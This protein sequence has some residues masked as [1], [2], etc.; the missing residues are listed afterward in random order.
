MAVILLAE[1]SP[2]HT[3]LMRSLLEEAAH[4]VHCVANGKDAMSSI[5]EC[6]PDLVVTDLRMPEMNGLELVQAVAE[7]CPELPTIVVTARGSEALAV[8]ALALGAINFVPKNSLSTLLAHV[9]GRT[10]RM[11]Q[12]DR[13]YEDFSGQLCNPEYSFTLDNQIAGIEPASFY[14]VQSLAAAGRMNPTL[15][16]RVGTAVASALFNAICFGNLELQENEEAVKR[17]LSGDLAGS[18]DVHDRA[19]AEPYCQRKVELKV[20]V[21]QGDTRILV[22]HE[23]PGRLTRMTPAPGTPESFELEQC[24]GL[25][26]M[27]SFMDDV[28]FHSDYS[29]VVMVKSHPED[30]DD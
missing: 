25:M 13:L 19:E 27:T 18:Q 15:R 17:L 2:T 24:R 26:L 8:D 9:V 28:L 7:N 10:V 11:S 20:S 3:A 6:C 21:G 12:T 14:V 1:D 29:E 4:K 22:S 16:M 30:C 5:E 23:G